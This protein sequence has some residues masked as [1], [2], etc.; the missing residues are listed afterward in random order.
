MKRLLL[1]LLSLM[2]GLVCAQQ[3]EGVEGIRMEPRANV[4][5]YDD[6][7]AIEKL[8][9]SDSPYWIPLDGS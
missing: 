4:I 9:Y 5:T 7:N 8:R 2:G 1:L 3:P 6:E